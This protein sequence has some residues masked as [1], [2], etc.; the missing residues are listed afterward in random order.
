MND[1]GRRIVA[2]VFRGP[3]QGE[4]ESH[5]GAEQPSDQS[6]AQAQCPTLTPT[7]TRRYGSVVLAILTA[8]GHARHRAVD[9]T[10]S[11]EQLVLGRPMRDERSEAAEI[12]VTH[13]Q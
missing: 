11:F 13:V 12:L 7:I 3:L 5:A 10:A 8:L 2:L 6:A 1:R 9:Q 4:V